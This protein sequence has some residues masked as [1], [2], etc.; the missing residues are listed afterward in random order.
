VLDEPN[1]NLDTE[2]EQALAVALRGLKARGGIGVIVSHRPS[3]L[4]AVDH[5]LLLSEGRMQAFGPRDAV[6]RQLAAQ[7]RAAAANG[8][9]HTGAAAAAEAARAPIAPVAPADNDAEPASAQE[10]AT[11][12]SSE[13]HEGSDATPVSPPVSLAARR[14]RARAAKRVDNGHGREQH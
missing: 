3:V 7:S 11:A 13:E 9:T 14:S 2:G 1:S 6:L 12:T 5:I 4:A 8:K 10:A